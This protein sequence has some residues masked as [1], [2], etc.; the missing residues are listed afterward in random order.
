MQSAFPLRFPK[1]E[2]RSGHFSIH[3]RHSTYQ[4]TL[5]RHHGAVLTRGREMRVLSLVGNTVIWSSLIR[6]CRTPGRWD[7]NKGTGKLC[8]R[9]RSGTEAGCQWTSFPYYIPK[10]RIK[11]ARIGFAA[12]HSHLSFFTEFAFLRSTAAAQQKTGGSFHEVDSYF[13]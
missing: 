8:R 2:G 12:R 5:C 13:V 1:P 7:S 6:E 10:V 4:R 11:I 9:R 3:G